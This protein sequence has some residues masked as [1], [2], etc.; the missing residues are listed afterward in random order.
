MRT[1]LHTFLF[2]F[3]SSAVL[4]QQPPKKEEPKKQENKEQKKEEGKPGEPAKKDDKASPNAPPGQP[5]DEMAEFRRRGEKFRLRFFLGAGYQTLHPAILSEAGPAWQLNNLIRAADGRSQPAFL[6]EDTGT[7]PAI[8]L[9]WGADFTYRDRITVAVERH[10]TTQTYSTK[11]PSKVTFLAPG[12][13]TYQTAMYEGLRLIKWA[14]RRDELEVMYLHPISSKGIK[15][16][17]FITRQEYAENIEVSMGSLIATRASSTDGGVLTW[18]EGGS[19]PATYRTSGWLAGAAVRYQL[20]EWLGFTYKLSPLRRSGDFNMSGYQ[21]LTSQTYTT[22]GQLGPQTLQLL[23]PLHFGSF[24]DKGMRHVLETALR[25]YCRYSVHLGFVKED[26]NR[27]YSSYFGYTFSP[28][29]SFHPKTNGL[30]IGEMSQSFRSSSLEV[31]LKF[32]LHFYL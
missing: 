2:L 4:A 31:Y 22:A 18:S 25:L 1:L 12:N 13:A 14:E 29:T 8:P 19:I 6:V 27:T 28:T 32:G 3:F 21:I 16:G 26:F 9:R 20:F 15:L 11:Y 24:Q 10:F 17:G 5:S 7:I 23:A 30:G